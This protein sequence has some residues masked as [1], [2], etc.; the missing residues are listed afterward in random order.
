MTS[1]PAACRMCFAFDATHDLGLDITLQAQVR[2]LRLARSQERRSQVL[3]AQQYRGL[4]L[5]AWRLQEADRH[6]RQRHDRCGDDD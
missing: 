1:F 4:P 3:L 6:G 2:Y 5:I